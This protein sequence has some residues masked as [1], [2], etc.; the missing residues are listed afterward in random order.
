[1]RKAIVLLFVLALAGCKKKETA[2][3]GKATAGEAKSNKLSAQLLG[4]WN[5][6]SDGTLAWEFLAEGKCKAFGNMDCKYE[7][8]SEA[9]PVLKLRYQSVDTWEDIEV[10]FKGSDEA[11]WKNL[12]EAKTDPDSAAT[13]L[14][15]AK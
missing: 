11:S 3:A 1:M 15:R 13:D 4:K 6:K 5:D 2:E 7:V 12:T 14:V 10:T 9:A 8:V